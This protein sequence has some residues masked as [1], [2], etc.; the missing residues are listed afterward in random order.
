M[1][2]VDDARCQVVPG[3]PVRRGGVQQQQVSGASRRKDAAFGEAQRRRRDLRRHA[4][5]LRAGQGFGIEP[6]AFP[7][8]PREA[9]DLQHV[10]IA[11]GGGAVGRQPHAHSVREHLRQR[12]HLHAELLVGLGCVRHISALRGEERHILRRGGVAMRQQRGARQIEQPQSGDVS[13][14]REAV[15]RQRIAHLLA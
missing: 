11:V 1:R 8:Q 3:N 4:E 2:G 5:Q 9:Q 12:G 15:A 10:E 14:R 7:V 13:R 6:G